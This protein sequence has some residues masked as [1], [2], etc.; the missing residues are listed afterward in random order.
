[1]ENYLQIKILSFDQ[2]IVLGNQINCFPLHIR[3]KVHG[4]SIMEFPGWVQVK[5]KTLC[6]H[7]SL[8]NDT[9]LSPNLRQI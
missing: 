2:A 8:K 4:N 1:M 5:E 9:T 3:F 7:I 6:M